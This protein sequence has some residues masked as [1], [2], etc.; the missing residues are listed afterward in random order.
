MPTQTKENYLKA[1]Y[2]L[3]QKNTDIS[4]TDL[5]RELGVSKPTVNDMVKSAPILLMVI[6]VPVYSL[7]QSNSLKIPVS[8]HTS[9]WVALNIKAGLIIIS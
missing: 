4:L 8:G 7:V 6:P 5:G 2:H 3:H 9:V 1:L